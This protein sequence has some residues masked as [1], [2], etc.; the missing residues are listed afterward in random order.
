[1]AHGGKREGSGRKSKADEL[2]AAALGVNAITKEFG[3]VEDYWLLIANQAR[4][5]FPHLKLI[6]EHVYGRAK[7]TIDM[8]IK[9]TPTIRVEYIKNEDNNSG[10]KD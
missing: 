6:H 2:G 10:S 5:S 3:S 7:E 1:M 8:D 9:G 4:E